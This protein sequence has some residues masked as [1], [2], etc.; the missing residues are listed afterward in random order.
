[1]AHF[2]K[3]IAHFGVKYWQAFSIPGKDRKK[4]IQDE[5]SVKIDFFINFAEKGR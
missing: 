1:M 2:T 4:G 3:K 5:P